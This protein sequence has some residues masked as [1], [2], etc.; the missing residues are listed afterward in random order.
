L[1]Q[2][3]EPAGPADP[4]VKEAQPRVTSDPG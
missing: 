3:R 1:L 2:E 4:G